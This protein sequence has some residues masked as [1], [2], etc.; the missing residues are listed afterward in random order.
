VLFGRSKQTA[1]RY[2][3]GRVDSVLTDLHALNDAPFVHHEGRP[4]RQVVAGAANLFLSKRDT[5]LLKHFPVLVAQQ[6][7]MNVKLSSEGSVGGGT[8]GANS[9]DDGV[10]CFQLWPISLIGFEF[11]ASSFCESQDI[12]DENDILFGQVVAQSHFFPIVAQK[13]EVRCLVPDSE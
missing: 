3:F 9:Q 4:L 6:R 10:A 11:T 8:V 12:E 7:K 5:V 13:R 2:S 1:G